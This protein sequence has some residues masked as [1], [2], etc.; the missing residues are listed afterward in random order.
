VLVRIGGV[1]EGSVDCLG[2]SENPL[3][4]SN[5]AQLWRL[6]LHGSRPK[7]W[8]SAS[9]FH[10][11]WSIEVMYFIK[12]INCDYNLKILGS[13][14]FNSHNPYPKSHRHFALK[15]YIYKGTWAQNILVHQ[16]IKHMYIYDWGSLN[17]CSTILKCCSCSSSILE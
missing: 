13:L 8:G 17:T 10:M 14:T 6:M 16:P 5:L 4:C 3:S 9:L 1:S 12:I 11:N 7:G 15:K 2:S